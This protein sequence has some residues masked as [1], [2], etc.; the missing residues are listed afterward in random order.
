MA[1]KKHVPQRL[2]GP[3]VCEFCGDDGSYTQW[4][5]CP[6]GDT[7]GERAEL[8]SGPCP[9]HHPVQ[10]PDEEETYLDAVLTKTLRDKTRDIE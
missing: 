10:I 3:Y 6:A 1:R 7:S 4:W 2:T 9:H 5:D 8:K